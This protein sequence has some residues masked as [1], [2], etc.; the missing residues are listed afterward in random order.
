MALVHSRIGRVFYIH[1]DPFAGGIGSRVKI[2]CRTNINHHFEVFR[3]Y[4]FENT[5]IDLM[6]TAAIYC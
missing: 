2:H 3:M 6:Y 5:L 1:P 4:E